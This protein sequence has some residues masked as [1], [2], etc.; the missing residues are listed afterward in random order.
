MRHARKR[1]IIFFDIL[2]KTKPQNTKNNVFKKEKRT[3]KRHYYIIMT[4][5]QHLYL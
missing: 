1:R 4:Q 5:Y 3:D 2:P